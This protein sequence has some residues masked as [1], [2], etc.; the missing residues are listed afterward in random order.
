MV[1]QPTNRPAR[2]CMACGNPLQPDSSF[3]PTCGQPVQAAVVDRSGWSSFRGIHV[4]LQILAW[5]FGWWFL[6]HF[7]IWSGTRWR[8]YWK[9]AASAPLI[10]ITIPFAFV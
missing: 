10:L 2:Y 4:S 3:C 8:W 5:L 7:Y 1:E 9:A 6:V